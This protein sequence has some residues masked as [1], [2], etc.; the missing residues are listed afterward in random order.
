MHTAVR[1]VDPQTYDPVAAGYTQFGDP[2]GSKMGTLNTYLRDAYDNGAVIVPQTKADQVC[3]ED[4]RACGVAATWSDPGDGESR[5][6]TVRAKDVVVACGALE[7]PRCC[8]APASAARPSAEPLPAPER[9]H[10]RRL[11]RGPGRV[12]G[13]AAG[14]GR[15][16]SSATSA[17]A[18][19]ARRGL[20]V[21]LRRLRLP[22]ARRDGKQ[23]KEAMSKLGRM[24]DFLFILRDH[25]GGTVT[26]D[27]AGEAV[28]TY[29]L[30]DER[31]VAATARA[32]A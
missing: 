32:C 20:A 21:V 28:H 24:A 16:T 15:W 9:R 14:R 7:T 25:K 19:A 13:T 11:R 4:G 27:E 30:T 5:R 3:V 26:I 17:T 18:T 1:N 12:V 10:L 6:V 23:A 22:A 2:T 31:D 8:C 29:E